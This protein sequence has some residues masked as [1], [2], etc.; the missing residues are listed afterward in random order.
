MIINGR[1]V[2]NGVKNEVITKERMKGMIIMMNIRKQR[3]MKKERKR[4]RMIIKR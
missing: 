2:E 3:E 1:K 4:K